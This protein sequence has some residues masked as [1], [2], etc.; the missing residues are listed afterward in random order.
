MPYNKWA[1]PQGPAETLRRKTGCPGT[2]P[3]R[4]RLLLVALG[5]LLAAGCGTGEARPDKRAIGLSVLTLTNPFFKE[6]ADTMSA[7]AAGHGYEVVVVSGEFDPARQDKQVNDFL[8]RK[9]DAIVL[10]PCDS[11]AIGPV[12]QEA[13][14]AG[15]PVFTVDIGCQAAGAQVV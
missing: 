8:V 15:V 11:K 3:M 13:N 4:S 9:V 7:E 5:L 10:C 12:I 6:I 2:S 1:G 14:A